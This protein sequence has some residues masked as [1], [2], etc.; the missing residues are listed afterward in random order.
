MI[1]NLWIEDSVEWHPAKL[2]LFISPTIHFPSWVVHSHWF[3]LYSCLLWILSLSFI[4]VPIFI[5][6]DLIMTL[7][8]LQNG[9]AKFNQN[10]ILFLNYIPMFYSEIIQQ[11][12][13]STVFLSIYY[14]FVYW[15]IYSFIYLLFIY[16]I[17]VFYR[18]WKCK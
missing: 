3:S 7:R 2:P 10:N 11:L 8:K 17:L 12:S 16:L 6:F 1:Y 13:S 9:A 18:E 15:F 14:L 4:F 5:H